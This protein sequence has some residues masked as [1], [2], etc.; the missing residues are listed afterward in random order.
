MIKRLLKGAKPLEYSAHLIPE[1]GF[2]SM[3]KLYSDGFLIAGDAAQMVNPSHREGSNMAM[4][5]GRLAAETVIEAKQKGNFSAATLKTYET[6]LRDSFIMPDLFDH[7]DLES[8]IEKHM[9]IVAEGPELLAN[10]A[11]E[12]FHVDGRSKRDA[13]KSILQ[14]V[15]RNPAVRELVKS[16]LTIKNEVQIMK[17]AIKMRILLWKLTHGK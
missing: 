8:Q 5:A 17:M 7:K 14:R 11:Y 1:G 13:Q 3:P 2:N 4:T 15:L 6:K 9:D 16:E 10:S 12:Y